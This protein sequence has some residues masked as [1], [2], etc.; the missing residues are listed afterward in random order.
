[1]KHK[2]TWEPL[3]NI[4]TLESDWKSLEAISANNFFLSWHW[5]STWIEFHPDQNSIYILKLYNKDDV[6]GL[7]LFTSVHKAS[8]FYTYKSLLLNNTGSELDH[9]TPEYNAVLCRPEYRHKINSIVLDIFRYKVKNWDE[10]QLKRMKNPINEL[11]NR[12]QNVTPCFSIN[13]AD[14]R[15]KN[16]DYLSSLHS[17]T[18]YQIRRSERLYEKM[19][20]PISF[21][22]AQDFDH[23][24]Q[25]LDNLVELHNQ[26]W[27]NKQKISAFHSEFLIKFHHALIK[28]C[29]SDDSAYL[30]TV[31][32]GNSIIGYLYNYNYK[33]HIYCYQSAFNYQQDNKFKPGYV[34][35]HQMIEY[36]LAKG[37]NV[38]DFLA[39]KYRYKQS[40]ATKSNEM[41]S[42]V[43]HSKPLA[44]YIRKIGTFLNNFKRTYNDDSPE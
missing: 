11:S 26:Y 28:K 12:N 24:I 32:A 38:Y 40:L 43:H 36:H 10:I 27:E 5:I 9:I 34:S 41:Y 18:R 6:I 2:F 7:A 8:K 30:S 37:D 20:G 13:L 42:Y 14:I 39:G 31:M 3:D 22:I 35:H 17:N 25:T 44:L 1:M 33:K 4:K 23:Q 29:Q 16:T 21:S 19:F 15:Q